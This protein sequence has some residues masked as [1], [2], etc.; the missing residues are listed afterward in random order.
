[1]GDNHTS[2]AT[3]IR[4]PDRKECL[5]PDSGLSSSSRENENVCVLQGFDTLTF[6]DFELYPKGPAPHSGTSFPIFSLLMREAYSTALGV[7]T[8]VGQ[9]SG[10]LTTQ[11]QRVAN[12]DKCIVIDHLKT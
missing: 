1:M 4:I 8:N 7:S 11:I 2:R 9:K 12:R 10:S 3:T 5:T 6:P